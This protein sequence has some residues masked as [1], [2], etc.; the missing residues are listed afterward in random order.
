MLVLKIIGVLAAVILVYILVVKVNGYTIK[1]YRYEFFNMGNFI[2]SAIGYGMIYFGSRWY[3][4]ALDKQGDI[5]NGIIV[6]TIGI[7]LILA[8]IY[9]NI[10]N[11]SLSEGLGFSL[12]QAPIYSVLSVAAIVALIVAIAYFSETKPVYQ[13]NNDE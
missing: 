1:K 5:L 2:A 12:L 13:I 3:I 11:T 8:V 10:T 9:I 4:S 6:C 7:I